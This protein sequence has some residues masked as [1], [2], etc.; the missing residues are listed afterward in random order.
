MHKFK[1][2]LVAGAES[3]EKFN[4]KAYQLLVDKKNM[5]EMKRPGVNFI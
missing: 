2:V 3:S 5:C 1:Y 4:L